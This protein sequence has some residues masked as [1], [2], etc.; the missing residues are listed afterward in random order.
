MADKKLTPFEKEQIESLKKVSEYKLAAE[1][2]IVACIY[3]QPDEIYNI[4][5]ELQE[6]SNNIWKVYFAIANAILRVEGKTELDDIT[7]GFY[8]E[9][10]S[11][12]RAKYEEYGGYKT[13]MDTTKYVKVENLEAYII[14]VRKWNAVMELARKGFPIKDRLSDYSDMTAEEIYNEFEGNL[15]HIFANIDTTTKS[16]DICDGMDSLIEK[17][18]IESAVGLKYANMPMM[19]AETG[20]QYLGSITLVGG[21]SNVGKST[22]CRTATLPVAIEKQEPVVIMLNEEGIDKWQREMLVW[23]CNN[24][25]G[26]DIQKHI[27]RDGH[28]TAEVKEQLYEARDWLRENTKN[29]LITVIPFQSYSTAK[30]IKE[31]KKYATLGV[32][33]FIL[34]TFKLD[35]G[36]VSENSWLSMQQSMVDINDTIKSSALNVHIMI[37]FQLNK[38]SARQRFYTQDNVGLAKNIID[39]TSTCIMIRNMFEDEYADE[40]HELKVYRTEGTNGKTKIQVPIKKGTQ[41]QILFIIKNREGAANVRQIVLEHDLSRNILKEIGYCNV[42]MD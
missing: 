25:L 16:Y 29:H 15:N 1:A 34:D 14:E 36:K 19:T 39:P 12:L 13:I 27:V 30:A 31:I 22:F 4:N 6:L 37:T 5:L 9:K 20:G 40:P 26:Y 21:L 11:K 28:Y 17:L 42:P 24:V 32:K 3:K 38:G 35:K 2:N 23:T 8:L 33:Y 18:D 10:H 7:I 41:Y